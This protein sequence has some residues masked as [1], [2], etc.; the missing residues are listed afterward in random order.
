VTD[1][2]GKQTGQ[3]APNGP[4]FPN[5][6]YRLAQFTDGTSNSILT[7]EHLLGDFSNSIA[8]DVRDIFKS[9]LSPVT[10]MDAYTMCQQLAYTNLAYQSQSTQGTPW[11]EGLVDTGA[12]FKVV[13]PPN[14]R[15]CE[16]MSVARITLTAAS[17]HPGGANIGFADGSVHFIKNSI[18]LN[19]WWAL[20]SINGG[21][22]VS[23]DSY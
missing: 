4:F 16:F 10:L 14:L 23:S 6:V 9:P 13:E 17:N 22:V 21:D 2:T 20:G 3:P 11:L 19:V 5:T 7:G 15:S 12:C 8:T 1:P 18:A